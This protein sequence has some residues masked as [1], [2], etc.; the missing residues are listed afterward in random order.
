M[1]RLQIEVLW[2][3]SS[4]GIESGILGQ[5]YLGSDLTYSLYDQL[6][7]LKNWDDT[8]CFPCCNSMVLGNQACLA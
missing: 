2:E 8:T 4:I 7:I 1:F 3:A 6:F 5:K